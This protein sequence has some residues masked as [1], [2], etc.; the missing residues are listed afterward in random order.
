MVPPF[1]SKKC[2][3]FVIRDFWGLRAR[4]PITR[5]SSRTNSYQTR[6][7][8]ARAGCRLTLSG[9]TSGSVLPA[10]PS[11][12]APDSTTGHL[13]YNHV[14]RVDRVARQSVPVLGHSEVWH[15]QPSRTC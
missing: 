5:R 13:Q 11:V 12:S 6:C 7:S 14:D 8:H 3:G 4:T 1:V 15:G 9:V 2:L 10:G